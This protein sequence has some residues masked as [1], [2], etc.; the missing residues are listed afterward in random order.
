M[1][2]GKEKERY[3]IILELIG[4]LNEQKRLTDRTNDAIVRLCKLD[5]QPEVEKAA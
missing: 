4:I 5:N 3:E 1:L 2:E